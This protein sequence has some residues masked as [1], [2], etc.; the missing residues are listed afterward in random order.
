[1]SSNFFD[2]APDNLVEMGDVPFYDGQPF[3][4]VDDSTAL[5]PWKLDI[6][7]HRPRGVFEFLEPVTLKVTLTNTSSHPQMIDAAVLEDSS[8]FTL[9]IGRMEGRARFWRPFAQYCFLPTPRVLEPQQSL[10][11]SFFVGSGL[12]GWYFAEPGAY[13]LQAVLKT[14]DT[15]VAT[16]LL[17]IRIAH[18]RSWDEEIV[19][20]N[21]FT[22]DV[23]RAF[24][25]GATPSRSDVVQTLR[26]VVERLPDRAVSYHAAL[27]LA[28][29]TMRDHRILRTAPDEERGFNLVPAD[30]DEACRFFQRALFDNPDAAA[31][32]LGSETCRNLEERYAVYLKQS[33]ASEAKAARA[34]PHQKRK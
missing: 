33:G 19:A 9:V 13:R 3:F 6:A 2:N 23:G 25:F 27:A 12:D 16:N 14:P 32:S 29:A 24:A 15:I 31:D 1:V 7:L 10:N 22:R 28:Q 34:K 30:H 18:P 26:E 11:A 4:D 8:N 17:R 21:F 20:Q 5:R